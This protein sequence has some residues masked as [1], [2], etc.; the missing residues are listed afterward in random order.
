MFKKLINNTDDA[1]RAFAGTV[2]ISLV[3][4][5]FTVISIGIAGIAIPLTLFTVPL[6]YLII[7]FAIASAIMHTKVM[8]PFFFVSYL[9]ASKVLY[10]VN[11]IYD[12]LN[13]HSKMEQA[14]VKEKHNL[15]YEKRIVNG[16]LD[17]DKSQSN[18]KQNENMTYSIFTSLP[19]AK[20]EDQ[21]KPHSLDQHAENAPDNS[22][23]MLSKGP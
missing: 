13:V 21:S 11:R 22:Q 20:N 9:T 4:F 5:T 2:L 6:A 19:S 7:E 10:T 1:A 23:N 18:E 15:Q 12:R 3:I 14:I 8:P 16:F 17:S